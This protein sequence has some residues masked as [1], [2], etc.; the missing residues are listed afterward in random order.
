MIETSYNHVLEIALSWSKLASKLEKFI[1]QWFSSI[2]K[3]S[4]FLIFSFFSSQKVFLN[5]KLTFI[6]ELICDSCSLVTLFYFN[7]GQNKP[8][9]LGRI[10]NLLM[11]LILFNKGQTSRTMVN[12]NSLFILLSSYSFNNSQ[13]APV[14][15][16]NYQQQ[17]RP[18]SYKAIVPV[19]T[20]EAS[21][22]SNRSRKP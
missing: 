16:N 7:S 11:A 12:P 22:P 14:A 13:Q 18:S 15:S 10:W 6:A 20:A 3:F 17:T 4:G 2:E 1:L 5:P 19:A 21:V 8:F 9:F